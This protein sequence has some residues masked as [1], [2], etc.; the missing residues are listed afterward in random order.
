MLTS[1]R[2]WKGAYNVGA[3]P[4]PLTWIVFF[5]LSRMIK[6]Q[7]SSWKPVVKLR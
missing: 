4:H 5:I 1:Q 2:L 7:A 6:M 3:E